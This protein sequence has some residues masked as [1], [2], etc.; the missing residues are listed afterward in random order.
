MML[1]SATVRINYI[2]KQY[3]RLKVYEKF[4][5]LFLH[6]TYTYTYDEYNFYLEN[7]TFWS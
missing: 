4:L 5:T 6:I 3:E 2:I 7:A 1:L